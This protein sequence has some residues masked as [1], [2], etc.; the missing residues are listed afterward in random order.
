MSRVRANNAPPIPAER[1]KA[2][3]DR[4]ASDAWMLA[5][6]DTALGGVH[7]SR[8]ARGNLQYILQVLGRVC[9]VC[10]CACGHVL[11]IRSHL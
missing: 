4:A 1:V 3:P 9:I 2:F 6:G 8:D 11:G 5:D 10:V 7:F